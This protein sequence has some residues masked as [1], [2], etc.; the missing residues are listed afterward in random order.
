[1][2]APDAEI[3]FYDNAVSRQLGAEVPRKSLIIKPLGHVAAIGNAS[4]SDSGSPVTQPWVTPLGRLI[5]GLKKTMLW[6]LLL[7]IMLAVPIAFL[8]VAYTAHAAELFSDPHIQWGVK[9]IAPNST[10]SFGSYSSRT[11]V[12]T[13]VELRSETKREL[14]V[15]L[16]ALDSAYLI[17]LA[18]TIIGTAR[19]IPR[20]VVGGGLVVIFASPLLGILVY[21]AVGVLIGIGYVIFG[22]RLRDVLENAASI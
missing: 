11:Q 21:V 9:T 20:L 4:A 5:M 3:H 19:R 14:M 7:A 16:V 17:G 10:R 6:R 12:E 2:S 22:M 8:S 1:L 13:R 18:L 15:W